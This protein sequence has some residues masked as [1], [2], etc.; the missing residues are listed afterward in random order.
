[1]N[2]AIAFK[3]RMTGFTTVVIDS[4]QMENIEQALVNKMQSAP[5]D[6]FK[7][8]PFVADL[9]QASS[10]SLANL[11]RL[12]QIFYRQELLLIGVTNHK[13]DTELLSQAG[14]ANIAA[15]APQ[16][17]ASIQVSKN[18]KS[19]PTIPSPASKKSMS[20]PHSAAEENALTPSKIAPAIEN[21]AA[22]T[23]IAKRHVRSGQRLYAPEGDLVIIGI[24]GAGAEVIADGNIFILGSLRGRAFAG[25]KGDNSAF[26]YCQTLSAE[27]ISIAGNYQTMEQLEIH[28][29]K[30]NILI[31]LGENETMQIKKLQ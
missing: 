27:L 8:V 1:M 19:T 3:T 16:R 23:K 31:T 11:E 5:K 26:I 22:K 6:F 25:A 14:L 2:D 7:A 17:E 15:N 13:L 10:L 28:K 18:S 9:Q 29:G 12:K 20:N 30:S 21:L 4:H 24:V